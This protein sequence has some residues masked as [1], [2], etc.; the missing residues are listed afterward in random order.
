MQKIDL[1]AR[2]FAAERLHR[3][4]RAINGHPGQ[5]GVGP[6]FRF[7]P[8]DVPHGRE[9]QIETGV[10]QKTASF[11]EPDIASPD[12][13]RRGEVRR[14]KAGKAALVLAGDH[15]TRAGTGFSL[16]GTGD[17]EM[18]DV[19]DVPPFLTVVH[20]PSRSPITITI[21][22]S[23]SVPPSRSARPD[24]RA[25]GTG[26]FT[27]GAP[28]SPGRSRSARTFCC[29]GRGSTRHRP[30]TGTRTRPV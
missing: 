12:G 14:V 28:S 16:P 6:A 20:S 11:V 29:P 3:P 8:A 27:R 15:Q 4:G 21:R 25:A 2:R 19:S 26:R 17:V 30:R 1:R 10:R 9:R 24:I 13:K 7:V 23:Q 5:T 18:C 22:R